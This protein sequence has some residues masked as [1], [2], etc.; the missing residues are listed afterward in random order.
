MKKA[1]KFL[2]VMSLCL[3]GLASC[4]ETSSTSVGGG[5]SNSSTSTGGGQAQQDTIVVSCPVEKTDFMREQ[6]EKFLTDNSLTSQYIIQIVNNAEGDVQK[7]ISDWTAASAPDVYAFASD[8]QPTLMRAGALATVPTTFANTLTQELTPAAIE[9]VTLANG[10]MFGYPY[11]GDN[12]YFLYYNTEYVSEDEVDTMDHL[13]AA[14]EEHDVQL[15]YCLKEA[16]YGAGLMFTFG[17]QYTINY[18]DTGDEVVS[19]NA[20]FN[21]EKGYKAGK[22]MY[23]L[24]HNPNVFSNCLSSEQ[25]AP[26]AENNLGAVI[27]GSWNY[28][29]FNEATG[30]KLKAAK[31]PTVTVDGETANL[32][33]FLGYKI[34]GVNPQ[35][36]SGNTA[37]LSVLHQLA[38]YLV[39]APVQT[40]FYEEFGSSPC[41]LQSLEDC[42]DAMA[43]DTSVLALSAQAE[44]AFPQVAVPSSVWTS[45]QTLYT[46]LLECDGSDAAIKAAVDTYND[47][48]INSQV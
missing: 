24:A 27:T 32:S 1:I 28:D 12:G 44:F 18:N 41:N 33:S 10:N 42:A 9:S 37:R 21:T 4:G 26:V 11:T 2:S 43:E 7:N 30:G 16:W 34:Y 17:A 15:Q 36:S 40:A 25:N 3:L 46:T 39:S 48:L 5:G 22:A 35:K 45:A 29:A 20:D 19:I 23:D 31:L 8:Q 47:A 38:N 6:A 13:L 14:L